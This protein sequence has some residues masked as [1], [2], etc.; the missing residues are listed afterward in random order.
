MD[1][2]VKSVGCKGN[3]EGFH[4]RDDYDKIGLSPCGEYVSHWIDN[5]CTG[6]TDIVCE[7]D[8]EE[9]NCTCRE[10]VCPCGSFISHKVSEPCTAVEK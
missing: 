5:S 8:P 7:S 3:P 1:N 4:S 6:R 10:G 2:R 9:H